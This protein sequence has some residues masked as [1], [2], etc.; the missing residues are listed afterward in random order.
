MTS[1]HLE[2]AVAVE[3]LLIQSERQRGD[4][5]VDEAAHRLAGTAALAVERGGP[6]GIDERGE[7]HDIE[8]V[9]EAPEAPGVPLVGRSDA[10]LHHDELGHDEVVLSFD[11]CPEPQVGG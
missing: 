4:E 5:A 2:V 7:G 3:H 8:A 1:Q 10:E 6:V 11:Q 9:E